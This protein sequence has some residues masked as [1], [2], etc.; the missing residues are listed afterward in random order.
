MEHH[1]LLCN[2]E[3]ERNKQNTRGCHSRVNGNEESRCNHSAFETSINTHARTHTHART[4]THTHARARAHTHT[5]T[6]FDSLGVLLAIG[7]N[8]NNNGY[9]RV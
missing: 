9:Q 2:M 7:E 4:L 3:R 5:D 6:V 8:N 1:G